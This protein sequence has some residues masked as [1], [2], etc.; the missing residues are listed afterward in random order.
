MKCPH[1]DI[2]VSFEFER[3]VWKRYDFEETGMGYGIFYAHCPECDNLVVLFK[4]GGYEQ[5]TSIGS[6]DTHTD[7]ETDFEKVTLEEIIYPKFIGRKVESEVPERYRKDF[8][9]L[10]LFYH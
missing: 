8:W 3:S 4:E 1:C 5:D 2:G 7:F 6:S 10:A 9:K